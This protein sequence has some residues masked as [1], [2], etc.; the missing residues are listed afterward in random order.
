M[1]IISI[2]QQYLNVVLPRFLMAR[3]FCDLDEYVALTLILLVFFSRTNAFVS[4]E[5]RLTKILSP[6]SS[7]MIGW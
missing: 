5:I 7:I 2:R 1:L 4:V 3:G 6:K